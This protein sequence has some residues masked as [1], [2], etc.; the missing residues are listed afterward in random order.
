MK[1]SRDFLRYWL[2][3]VLWLGL[4]YLGSTDWMSTTRT[5]RIIGP[6]LRWLVP[7][8]SDEAI[9]RV[10]WVVRK[11]AHM[12][13]YGVLALLLWR[14]RRRPQPGDPRPWDGREA[15]STLLWVALCGAADEFHQSFV[16]SRGSAVG[17][18]LFDL[19][20]GALALGILFAWGR[21]RR[22]W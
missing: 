2:P 15:R 13:E 19:A 6:L 22:D 17:D 5:S 21:W 10:Q 11:G 20:G 9:R 4:I 12:A 18:V 3:V 8:I 7:E 16:V 14:A 1:G